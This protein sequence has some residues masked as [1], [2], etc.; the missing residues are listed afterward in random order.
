MTP[1]RQRGREACAPFDP[2]V[3]LRPAVDVTPPPLPVMVMEY[4]PAVALL[5]TVKVRVEDPDPGAAMLDG[6]KFALTPD[7]SP[8]SLPSG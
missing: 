5:L 7:G 8:P 6:L 2:I 4:V 1:G 3:R